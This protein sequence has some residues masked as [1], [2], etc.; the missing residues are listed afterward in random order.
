VSD[1]I[2]DV[3]SDLTS[4]PPDLSALE[5]L[6]FAA[7]LFDLD[8]TL[9]DSTAAVVRSWVT[10]ALERGIDPLRL[11]GYHGVPS[12]QIVRELVDPA[13]VEHASSRIDE[14]ELQDV[15]DIVALPGAEAALAALPAGRAAIVTSCT[16]SLAQARLGATGV[17]APGVLVTADQVS[18]GKPDPEPFLTAA[19]R[20]GVP[21]GRCLVV[22][23]APSGLT[24]ARAA[25]MAT[26][27]VTTTT[28]A[29]DLHADAVVTNLADVVFTA[30]PDGV[31]VGAARTS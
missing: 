15:R 29:D 9:V 16:A 1:P 20:L 5:G 18:R 12:A 17:A 31:R 26:L 30:G 6:A 3:A 19:E 21:P 11:R 22:E 10:W 27:A 28:P 13:D 24:A 23:D 2:R 4:A 7:V 25:G 14:L 8:G